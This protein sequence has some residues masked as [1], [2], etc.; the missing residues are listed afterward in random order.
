MFYDLSE[1][2][3]HVTVIVKSL[4]K[5]FMLFLTFLF[6]VYTFIH[7]IDS[8][9]FHK[10]VMFAIFMLILHHYVSWCG[11]FSILPAIMNIL[12]IL[13]NVRVHTLHQ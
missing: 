7:L 13:V 12:D 10:C 9:S 5:Y 11:L 8:P 4:T 1:I 2:S 6:Y 3:K